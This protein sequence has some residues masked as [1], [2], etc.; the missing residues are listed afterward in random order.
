MALFDMLSD[1]IDRL[2]GKPRGSERGSH[3]TLESDDFASTFGSNL[4]V[5]EWVDAAVFVVPAQTAYNVG[6]GTAE[7][8]STV[9]R[10]YA[11]FDDG[12]GNTVS[13]QV[14]IVTR[15]ARDKAVETDIS[16]VST[17]KIDA[18]PNDY[19]TQYAVPEILDTNK[20]GEDSKVVLQFKL[21][22]SSTGTSIDFS[23]S[24][25]ELDLTEY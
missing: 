23:A 9:G 13:G 7:N 4:E 5:D 16:S 10:W 17:S 3:F 1:P 18:D 15:N 11:S 20:V 14:R 2:S 19:R 21:K 24:D 8:E 6:F 25:F 12:S 22:S